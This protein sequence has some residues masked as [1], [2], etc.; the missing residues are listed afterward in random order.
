MNSY[1]KAKSNI[2]NK[3]MEWQLDIDNHSYSYGELAYFSSY[4]ERMAKR[5]GLIK[6]FKENGII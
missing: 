5:Y 1:Q 2:R 4:F 6:E 3:A